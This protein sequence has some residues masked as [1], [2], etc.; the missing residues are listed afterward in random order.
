MLKSQLYPVFLLIFY[1][2]FGFAIYSASYDMMTSVF[3]CFW[4]RLASCMLASGSDDGT[5]SI[6][7]L[8]LLKVQHSFAWVKC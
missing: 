5:F 1:L 8:R 3:N 7:D 4:I 2:F 6:R